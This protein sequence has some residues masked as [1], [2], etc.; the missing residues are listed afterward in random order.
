MSY[1]IPIGSTVTF[2]DPDGYHREAGYNAT[3]PP[4]IRGT[5]EPFRVYDGDIC[6][7]IGHTEIGYRVNFR[8]M[9]GILV[10]V[11]DRFFEP[12]PVKPTI[13][14]PITLEIT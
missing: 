13:G 2:T 10:L 12:P 14:P 6:T 1:K 5:C 11:A 9:P 7:I 8:K 3:L 4:E